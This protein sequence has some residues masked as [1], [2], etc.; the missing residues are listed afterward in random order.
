MPR[1]VRI[2]SSAIKLS[3]TL[4]LPTHAVAQ[5]HDLVSRI[6]DLYWLQHTVSFVR[7]AHHQRK[8]RIMIDRRGNALRKPKSNTTRR[9]QISKQPSH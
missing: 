2:G 9:H 3:S 7:Q 5:Q 1:S 6:L 8:Q 4:D